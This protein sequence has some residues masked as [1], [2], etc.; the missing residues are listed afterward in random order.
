MI[1]MTGT[2]MFDDIKAKQRQTWSS[3]DYTRVAW[4][5]VPV[6][7]QLVETVGLRPGSRVLDVATGTG[8]VAIAAAR[9]F[10]QVTGIDYVPG[11]LATAD[12]R[13]GAGGARRGVPAPAAP[14]GPCAA[15]GV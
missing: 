4:L 9:R 13:A 11:L 3:G 6:A 1:A 14:G 7:E 8:H 5:T 12:R 15:G 10:C 2:T